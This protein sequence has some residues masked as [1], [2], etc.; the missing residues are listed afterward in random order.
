MPQRQM[1]WWTR[2]APPLHPRAEPMV[3]G[4]KR[5]EPM[6]TP[7][8]V[9]H[10][11]RPAFLPGHP[12]PPFKARTQDRPD[13]DL[14][15][16]AGRITVLSFLG[17]AGIAAGRELVDRFMAAGTELFDDQAATFF[18]V[19]IDPADERDGR[20]AQRVPGFR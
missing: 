15:T 18:G 5:R 19:T 17:S 12:V 13:Y 20:L 2:A 10:A 9:A 11:L 4:E 14:G 1:A 7:A 3:S 8:S 16:A 6:P